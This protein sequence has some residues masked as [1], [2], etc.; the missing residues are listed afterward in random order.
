QFLVM[1]YLDGVSLHD[2]IH[3]RGA[4]PAERAAHYLYQ[5][6]AGLSALHARSLVHRDVKPA[7]L[8]LDRNGVVR[9]LDLGLVRSELDDDALTKGEGAK[10]VGTADYLPPEQAIDCSKVDSR[11]DIY[12]LGATAYY[13]LTGQPP[14]VAEKISHKLIAHQ[15]EEAKPLHL[16]RP[17]IPMD[18]SAIIHKML[19]KKPADRHESMMEVMAALEPW[20]M[21]PIGPPDEADFPERAGW[22]MPASSAMSFAARMAGKSNAHGAESKPI[23]RGITGG[24]VIRIGPNAHG[25][26]SSGGVNQSTKASAAEETAKHRPQP[27]VPVVVAKAPAPAPIVT[28]TGTGTST[29]KSL[30]AVFGMEETA[31]AVVRTRSS[32]WPKLIAVAV[33]LAGAAAAAMIFG[34]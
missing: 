7:N 33:V 3:R 30:H 32:L 14:F 11:A 9:V 12:A 20:L 24:S 18:L 28:T 16:M 4:I 8:L 23:M 27:A 34:K 25:S 13:L 5:V 26:Q 10:I 29:E 6:A 22:A 21:E 15:V 31:A 17:G 1:E 2:L 19:A